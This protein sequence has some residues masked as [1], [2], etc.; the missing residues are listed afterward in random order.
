MFVYLDESGDTGFKFNR[1]SSRYFVVAL[2]LVDDPLP[3]HAAVAQLR[4]DLGL[5]E[6][7]EFKF[8]HSEDD[9][10]LTFL[11]MLR[12]QD[13]KVRALVIDKHLMSREHMRERDV[14]YN[15]LV[16]MILTHDNQTIS[17]AMVIL[18]ESAK[19]KRSKQALTTYLRKALN[20]DPG[21]PKIRGVRYH[22][23][24]TDSLIQATDMVVGAIYA[25]YHHGNGEYLKAIRV[26]IGDLWEWQP[27]AQ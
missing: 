9:R 2:L 20:V 4:R 27:R 23:S 3:L 21:R 17:N 26:K 25:N 6:D 13:I 1:G 18:D 24:R 15:F 14:F 16:K 22:D 7:F 12:R 5:R 8:Y 19:S 10:R 11:R